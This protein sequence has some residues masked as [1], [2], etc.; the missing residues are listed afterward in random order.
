MTDPT[1]LVEQAEA[2]VVAGNFE[3]ALHCY[4]HL[5]EEEPQ[6]TDIA[7]RAGDIA[8]EANEFELAE[9]FYHLITK[10]VPDNAAAHLQ[11]SHALRRLG[12]IVEAR[13]EVEA[14]LEIMPDLT[15]AYRYLGFLHNALHDYDRAI[16]SFER[17]VGD[18]PNDAEAWLSYGEAMMSSYSR[19]DEGPAAISKATSLAADDRGLLLKAADRLI[20]DGRYVEAEALMRTVVVTDAEAQSSPMT[21]VWLA[22]TLSAQGRHREAEY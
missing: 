7:V 14:V 18:V 22:Y 9:R 3:P 6:R 1:G 12:R 16:Q 21:N 2:H 20:V 5:L 19:F 10:Y 4:A 13:D 15:E 11:R 8:M 17:V